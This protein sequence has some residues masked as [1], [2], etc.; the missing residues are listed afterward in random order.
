M[1]PTIDFK[2][3]RPHRGNQATGFEELTR[4]LVLAEALPNV[5]EIEHRGPGAD[6]GVEVLVKFEGGFSWGWQSK[7]F[8][9]LGISQIGQLKESFKSAAKSFGPDRKGRLTKFIVALPMNLSGSGTTETSDARKRWTGFTHWAKEEAVRTLSRE[10]EI[11]L[12]DETAFISRLQK[13]EGPYPGMLAY[14]FDRHVFTAEWFR[15]QL[16]SAIAALDERYH[17]EDHVDVNA[18]RVFDLVLHREIVRKDLHR[19]FDEVRSIH[20]IAADVAGDGVLPLETGLL[21]Q[22]NQALEQFIALEGAVDRPAIEAWPVRQWN[23]AWRAMVFGHLQP[24]RQNLSREL[25]AAGH[26]WNS[27]RQQ[28]L[29]RRLNLGSQQREAFGS[30]WH[31]YFDVEETGAILFVGEA[32][33]GKSHL[34]AKAAEDANAEG[35]PVLLLL[36][37]D[38]AQA[39]PR[40][41]ILDRLD[42]RG[43]SFETLLGALDAAAIAANSHALILIDALNEGW[44]LEVWPRELARFIEEIRRFPRLVFGVSCRSE[45]L[46]GTIPAGVEK[47]FLRIDVRGFDSF[48]EQERAA[49]VYLD[50]RG[51]VRPATPSLDPEFSNPLFLRIAAE[52]SVRSGQN[53]FPRGLRGAKQVFRFVFETRGRFLGAG[54][55]GTDDLVGPLMQSLQALAEAMATARRDYLSIWEATSLV[56]AVFAA[57]PSPAGRT[58]LDVL[59]G[60]GFVRKE[61]LARSTEDE[62]SPRSE[63]IRFTFQRLADQLMAEALLGRVTS[64]EEAFLQGGPLAFVV[65]N[66]LRKEGGHASAERTISIRWTWAGLGAALWIGIAER[67]GREL[68]DLPGVKETRPEEAPTWVG[69]EEPFKES[70]RWRTPDAFSQRTREIARWLPEDFARER[71]PLYL[72]V[73]LVP[74][75][76]WNIDDLH[77]VLM[78]TRMPERDAHWSSA[79]LDMHGMA[80]H[81]ANRSVDWCQ[82]ADLSRADEDTVRLTTVALCWFLTV[83]NR[84]LRDGATK[85]LAVTFYHHPDFIERTLNCFAAVDD[86]YVRERVFA[87]AYG[88]ALHMRSKPQ[89]LFGCARAAFNAI[90]KQEQTCRHMTLRDYARGLIEV[91]AARN[92]LPNDVDLVRCRPPYPSS[93]ITDWPSLF[94]VKRL[95]KEKEAASILWSTVGWIKEDGRPGM[96]GDFGR[97][98]MGAIAYAFSER[99]RD[100]EAPELPAMRK[101]AFWQEVRSINPSTAALVD[102]LLVSHDELTRRKNNT[103]PRIAI[104]KGETLEVVIRHWDEKD[105]GIAAAFGE[106]ADIEARFTANV[107]APLR[108]RYEAGKFLP[109][110]GDE[111]PFRF[112]LVRGQCW[113]AWRALGLGW[114]KELH[115]KVER[116]LRD[117]GDRTSYGVE[118]IGKKY[119][120]VAYNELCGYLIDH[121]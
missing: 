29:W 102:Q 84:R 73:A 40:T 85:A 79:F 27:E 103:V 30:P 38:F 45:Y 90:F 93:P 41:A 23:E 91:A 11:E 43:C 20:P 106:F 109:D 28:K 104:N 120:W 57:Y 25:E 121:H 114:D 58:W 116:H 53:A 46:D 42:L 56:N 10:I 119:Q 68:I 96:A 81:N 9:A 18:L 92:V 7:W 2:Q 95:A 16:D 47:Q 78:N 112:D 24:V 19:D 66:E 44:G 101:S 6:G 97:Y 113:V 82:N 26:N 115:G 1:S 50:R 80:F 13:R 71:L 94:E 54:R 51:I 32:G 17:P 118:R 5:R 3:L 107:P 49:R 15:K 14:W 59:R 60:N 65:E 22:L 37:Q 4:Q 83:S 35:Y 67:F 61:I 88:A 87:A 105:P 33:A 70:L 52:L 111:K 21:E 110:F 86:E 98:T 62:F 77:V 75:H 99:P 74:K 100:G 34:L 76:P 89:I 63:V 31:R 108:R 48:E 8:D 55:D 69:F 39:D 64:I 72:E 12:W 36:G 117:S